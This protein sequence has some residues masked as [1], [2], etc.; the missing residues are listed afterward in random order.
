MATHTWV[1]LQIPEAG[2]LADLAGILWDLQRARE[3]AQL[4]VEELVRP[5]PNWGL[6]E[7]LSIAAVVMYS[8]PFMGGVRLRLGEADLK[9]LT[10]EQ[11]AA[12]EHFRAYRDKHVAH[13]INVFEENIPRANYCVERVNEE[14]IT[15]ISYGGGRIT[16][17]SGG[18]LNALIDLAT[19]LD[20][21][22]RG[23]IAVEQQRLLPIVR[24]MPL[25]TVL[26]G[27]QK[28]FSANTRDVAVKRR[29]DGK[30]HSTR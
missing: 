5:N 9:G 4:L 1:D 23:R 30:R 21:H 24:S 10:V 29:G 27:G 12:H 3:F 15:G 7:P 14:G 13:S 11:R 8:R 16:S 17:L 18:E 28:G 19:V 25:E 2:S 20:L 22:V 6:M 26:A